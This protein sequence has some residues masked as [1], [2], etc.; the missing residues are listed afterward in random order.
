MIDRN[1]GIHSYEYL[2]KVSEDYVDIAKIMV[3]LPAIIPQTVLKKKIEI[4]HSNDILA[5]TGGQFLELMFSKQQVDNY[6]DDL[7]NAGFRLVEVSDNRF[8]I[9]ANAKSSLIKTVIKN[10]A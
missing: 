2:I 8:D 3:D 10:M 4:Y 7:V 5:F 9:S 1:L 6:F